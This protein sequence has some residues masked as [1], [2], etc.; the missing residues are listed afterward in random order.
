MMIYLDN[1][2]TTKVHPAVLT[3]MQENAQNYFFNA[4]T[5]YAGGVSA[6]NQITAARQTILHKLH[7]E[8]GQLIF[9]SGATEANH[10]IMA[11]KVRKPQHALV[12][13]SGD[14]NSVYL[15]AK[16]LG[17]QG[18]SVSHAPLQ[19]NGLIDIAA[20]VDL[21]TE[22]TTLFVFSLVN[23]DVGTLQ[24]AAALVQAIRAKSRTVHIHCD[25][26]QAFAKFDFNV[27]QLGLDSVTICAHKIHGPKGIGALWLRQ[28]VTLPER[29]GTLNNAG[30]VGFAKAATVFN[31]PQVPALHDYLVHHL[32]AGC[33]VN[34]INNNPYITNLAL[35]NVFGETVLNALS[36]KQIYVGLGSACAANA[37]NNRTLAAMKLS[38]Q[39][40][41]Q[42][43]RLSLGMDNTLDEIK[44]FLQELQAVLDLVGGH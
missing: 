28:G 8:H 24:D 17:E 2:A 7:G 13:T 36:A 3:A 11:H 15:Y 33:V 10:L 20:T 4:S 31:C 41:K 1:A 9:T 23:S 5:L 6:A 29:H 37:K 26:A 16:Q 42:V 14:H 21:I 34:G 43:L 35:P 32:P 22:Q 12:I 18:Y 30:I 19:P 38:P 25:A 44:T 39:K 27:E 40:Q